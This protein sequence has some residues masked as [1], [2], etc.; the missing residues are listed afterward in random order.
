MN[1]WMRFF[2]VGFLTALALTGCHKKSGSSSGGGGYL[3]HMD[4]LTTGD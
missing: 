2:L 3:S 4:K 1:K